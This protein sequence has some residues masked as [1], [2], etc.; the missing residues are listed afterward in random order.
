MS[1]SY[2]ASHH[3]PW[4]NNEPFDTCRPAASPGFTAER[5]SESA[6]AAG[7]YPTVTLLMSDSSGRPSGRQE[8]RS[9]LVFLKLSWVSTSFSCHS[10]Q[11]S[12]PSVVCGVTSKAQREPSLHKLPS[13]CPECVGVLVWWEVAYTQCCMQHPCSSWLLLAKYV[14]RLIIIEV[15]QTSLHHC[16]CN[17]IRAKPKKNTVTN[18]IV[19]NGRF[20][21]KTC[22]STI[23]SQCI[24]SSISQ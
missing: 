7:Q 1:A 10:S 19:A 21:S 5:T 17:C 6:H 22:V 11:L 8:N 18:S 2:S 9:F 20:C 14:R 12:S 24:V 16:A 4:P 15:R 13:R 23:L 3:V